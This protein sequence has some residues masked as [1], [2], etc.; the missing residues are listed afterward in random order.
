[1]ALEVSVAKREQYRASGGAWAGKPPHR[2][3]L[4]FGA[5]LC[6]LLQMTALLLRNGSWLATVPW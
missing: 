6:L 5:D 4:D 2:L 3:L 1:M